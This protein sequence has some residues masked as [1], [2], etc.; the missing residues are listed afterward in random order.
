MISSFYHGM[1]ESH[2]SKEER[3]VIFC[4]FSLKMCGEHACQIDFLLE[5]IQMIAVRLF[6]EDVI[7]VIIPNDMHRSETMPAIILWNAML[8]WILVTFPKTFILYKRFKI[9]PVTFC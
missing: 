3:M 8:N 7:F 6:E 9:M 1:F 5:V 2:A 4:C